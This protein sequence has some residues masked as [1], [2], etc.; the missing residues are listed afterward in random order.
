[1]EDKRLQKILSACGYGSRRDCEKII[2]EGRVA[3]NREIAKL[4]DRAIFDYDLITVDG[5]EI[6]EKYSEYI[7]IIVNKPINVLSDIKDKYNRIKVID[8]IDIDRYLFIAGRL[9]YRS[10][11]LILLTDD[12]EIANRL[13]HPRYEHEKEYLVLVDKELSN[14]QLE[15][16]R[17]GVVLSDGYKTLPAIV[18]TVSTHVEGYWITVILREGKKRQIREVGKKLEVHVNRIIRTRIGPISLGNLKSGKYR[19]LNEKE[20]FTLRKYCLV[21]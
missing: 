19:I 21:K 1:M 5:K 4:G 10:E 16:W 17:K 7:Y 15:K 2:N 13:T 11:G 9:D 20:I 12:G 3:V 14:T 8:L 6:S 18:D